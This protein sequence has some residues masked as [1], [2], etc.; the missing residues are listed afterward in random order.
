MGPDLIR[1]RYDLKLYLCLILVKGI[2]EI[3]FWNLE[4]V[5]GSA[6]M[7]NFVPFNG[8]IWKSLSNPSLTFVVC[9]TS[10]QYSGK[11]SARD[12]R[13]AEHAVCS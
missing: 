2:R 4:N 10:K 8:L 13:P 7:K 3:S 11:N 9:S 6:M 1:H 12:S 5:S